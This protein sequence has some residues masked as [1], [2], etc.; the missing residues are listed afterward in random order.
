MSTAA[1]FPQPAVAGHV[2]L[3]HPIALPT[4]VPLQDVNVTA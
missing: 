3:H 2:R 4:T 1:R